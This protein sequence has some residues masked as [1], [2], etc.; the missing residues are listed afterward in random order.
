MN[1]SAQ[2]PRVLVVDDHPKILKF[3][4]LDL[5]LRGFDVICAD[6]GEN[7]LKL[8]NSARPDVLLLDIAMPGMDGFEVIKT[9]RA[10]SSLPIIAFSA[11]PSNQHNAIQLGANDFMP[12]PFDSD[13]MARKI[14]ALLPV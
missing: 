9:L 1:K 7:A 10:S 12:K 14:Q 5:K 6:C 3:I 4:E 11:S 8:V 13:V 2:K